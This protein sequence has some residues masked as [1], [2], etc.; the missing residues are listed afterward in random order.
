ME[1]ANKAAKSSPAPEPAPAASS[2]A[3]VG[4]EEEIPLDED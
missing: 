1:A 2:E 3:F 4:D